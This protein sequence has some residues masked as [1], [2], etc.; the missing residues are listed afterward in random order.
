MAHSI[1][2]M[3][4][5]VEAAAQRRRTFREAASPTRW[6]AYMLLSFLG[7]L[8]VGTLAR[9][10]DVSDAVMRRHLE[11]MAKVGLVEAVGD[12]R[13]RRWQRVLAEDRAKPSGLRVDPDDE[14]A[15]E[16]IASREFSEWLKVSVQTGA[17]LVSEFIDNRM[18]IESEWRESA[19]IQDYVLYLRREELHELGEALKAVVGERLVTSRE[20]VEA[21]DPEARPIYVTT[22]AVRWL[23]AEG[24]AE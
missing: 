19:E 11:A 23:G 2:G 17:D 13:D 10:V 18:D 3:G 4:D 15:A 24:E 22:N 12:G 6:R 1:A 20:R 8:R 21:Q 9:L 14:L 5:S 7:P 16:L